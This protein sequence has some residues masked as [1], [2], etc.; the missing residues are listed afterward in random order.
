MFNHLLKVGPVDVDTSIRCQGEKRHAFRFPL[1]AFPLIVLIFSCVFGNQNLGAQVNTA[2]VVGTVADPT[3]AVVPGA[4]VK[5]LNIDTGI[6]RSA[7]S[8]SKGEYLFTL[9]QVGTYQV[10]VEAP[11]FEKF[12]A[13]S[14]ALS[15]GDRARVDATMKV[16]AASETVAV[17]ASSAPA[18]ETDSSAIGSLVPNQTV[19]DLP[20][21]QRNLT[22]LVRLSAGITAVDVGNAVGFTSR[23]E[24][25]R[26]QTAY[27]ANGQGSNT[28]TNLLDGG[29]NNERLYG[30]IGVRPSMD[31]VQEVKVLTNLYSAEVGR[32]AGGA[33]DVITKSG[34]NKFHG[35]LYD[36]LRNNVLD[37]K[38]LANQKVPELRQNQFGGS[39][40][41]RIL[42][43]KTFFFGD[44]EGFRQVSGMSYTSL[45]PTALQK[46]GDFSELASAGD[47]CEGE[48]NAGPHGPPP[49]MWLPRSSST[50]Q[51]PS[52][53][54]PPPPACWLA[55]LS[56]PTLA[57]MTLDT[58]GQNLLKLFPAPNVNLDWATAVADTFNY[59]SIPNSTQ[60]SGTYDVRIDHNFNQ[61]NTLIGHYTINNIATTTPSAFPAVIFG[62]QTVYGGGGQVASQRVQKLTADYLHIYRPELLLEL[63]ASYLR[64]SNNVMP[65]NGM[66]SSDALGWP[67]NDVSCINSSIGGASNGLPN[68]QNNTSLSYAITANGN[69]ASG[70]LGD[71][72]SLP[73]HN[74][75]NTFQYTGS[76]TW[77]H[78]RHAIK[79]GLSSIRRQVLY[80]QAGNATMGAFSFNGTVT[81]NFIADLLLGAAATEARG[82]E[83]VAQHLRTWEPSTYV[84]DDWRFNRWLTFNLGVRYEIYTPFTEVNGYM[85]NFDPVSEMIVSPDL[86]GAQHTGKA[87]GLSTT[88]T[89]I[90]PRI[91]FAASLGHGTVLR[92]GFGMT[93]FTAPSSVSVGNAPPFMGNQGCGV[94]G[95]MQPAVCTAPFAFT[96]PND[97]P[98][99]LPGYGQL[100]AGLNA[101][102]FA[103]SLALAQDQS[104][105]TRLHLMVPGMNMVTPYLEQWS[106]QLEKQIGANVLTL[107][108]VG[109]AGRHLPVTANMNQPITYADQQANNYPFPEINGANIGMT[110]TVGTSSYNAMQ[111]VY[112]RRL[113]QGL[114]TNVNYTWS[115]NLGLGDA[116]G[117]GL[118]SM[119]ECPRYGCQVDN[120]S[121]GTPKVVGPTVDWGN[122]ST[123]IRQRVGVMT[124]YRMP[125]GNSLKG[126]MGVIAKG[127][128][129]SGSGNWQTG[130]DFSAG[131]NTMLLG[132]M[133][134]RPNQIGNPYKAGPV[135]GS[136][137]TMTCPDKLGAQASDGKRYGFNPCAFVATA[138]TAADPN[139][140]EYFGDEARNSLFGPHTWTMNAAAFKDFPIREDMR[141]SF[142]AES[143]NLT[144]TTNDTNPSSQYQT[145]ATSTFGVIARTTSTGRQFQF[146]L[147]LT[148]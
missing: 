26:S 67:C 85:A 23:A 92:G 52:P 36:Y 83:L 114:T 127:W 141:L 39:L 10:S 58:V 57:G 27:T 22:A 2:D 99:A 80:Q 82:T 112:S 49:P 18:L 110:S 118:P 135:T 65:L 47:L 90:A 40:G 64:Y 124:S 148:F 7:T 116:G 44:Y 61:K 75:D 130:T 107:G 63:K 62:S 136:D 56:S 139:G 72:T 41:G 129:V 76:L 144:N 13:S 35:S 24:D 119:L 71:L 121:T 143:F 16:G 128:S 33:V 120:P 98:L 79:I 105:Y 37:S 19:M 55:G 137:P 104:S 142:R 30:I 5:I 123:D 134:I 9:L 38:T 94:Q 103:A 145:G 8:N 93:Y 42:K 81:G 131:E 138:N 147:R 111:L 108:Y 45:V 84:Q 14:I 122:A 12:V 74:I 6:V 51:A 77:S 115:H 95:S 54:Q 113:S 100:S 132:A 11:G 88:F 66:G 133:G 17:D 87:D 29:D 59:T 4:K 20:L 31:A 140:S 28:N 43:D 1:W 60:D 70:V 106:L 3:G 32:T 53:D 101:P 15:A 91:G 21:D 86:L 97:I 46:S 78:G 69:N 126:P 102:S 34:T 50:A 117:V 89:N 146:A 73:L 96:N 48:S 109:N 68:I 125:F 25:S